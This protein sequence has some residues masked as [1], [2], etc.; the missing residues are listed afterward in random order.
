MNSRSLDPMIETRLQRIYLENLTPQFLN[1][2]QVEGYEI[3]RLKP[4]IQIAGAIIFLRLSLL[5]LLF[6]TKMNLRITVKISPVTKFCM[7]PVLAGSQNSFQF[8]FY[9]CKYGKNCKIS[10]I[11]WISLLKLYSQN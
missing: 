4:R 2:C 9:I 3:R 8:A 1:H 6:F 11:D 10:I 5:T 7:Q